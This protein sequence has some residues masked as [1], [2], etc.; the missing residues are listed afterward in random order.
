LTRGCDIRIDLLLT[1]V[2]LP[3]MNGRQLAEQAKKSD[4]ISRCYSRRAIRETPSST[5]VGS[6]PALR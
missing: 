3:G 6:I 4:R 5:K 2:V 1:D